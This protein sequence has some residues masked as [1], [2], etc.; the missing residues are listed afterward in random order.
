MVR[1]GGIGAHGAARSRCRVHPDARR[2]GRRP[3]TAEDA[4]RS[5][6]RS[7][8][9]PSPTS[10]GSSARSPYILV[11]LAAI[12]FVTSVAVERGRRHRG[13]VVRPVGRLPHPGVHRRLRDVGP[14]RLHRHEPRRAR[15][16]ANRGGGSY[17]RDGTGTAGGVPH[18]W[19]GR[20]V[21]CRPRSD[22]R[23]ADHDDLPEHQLGDPHRIRVRRFA[24]RPVPARGRR[25]LHQGRRCRR[26]PGRQGR[27]GHSRGR[28]AQPGDDRRQRRRQRR[29]LRRHG[30]RPV[31]VVRGDPRRLDHPRCAGVP[32]DLPRRPRPVGSRRA[33]PARRPCDRRVGVD[34][35]RVHGA[36]PR[37]GQVG[38]GSD[39]PRL[40][41]RRRAHRRGHAD[42]RP[43]LRR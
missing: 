14:H 25:H 5:P 26:R 36:C 16:R 21:L 43:D 40:P 29:R 9:V 33:V 35:R 15:Q 13:A 6:R 2:A 42:R 41:H 22:R 37:V 1:S 7:R 38:D 20:H 3:G 4:S 17:G 30:R 19:R 39:Q 10:S 28:P 27:G 8:K 12:V 23:H 24:A 18:R 31:R 32:A 11:P 34:R